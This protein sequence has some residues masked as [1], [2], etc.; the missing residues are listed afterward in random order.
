M[1]DLQILEGTGRELLPQLEQNPDF[2]F[3]LVP[4][5]AETSEDSEE[6]QATRSAKALK[7]YGILRGLSSTEEFLR[8]KQ[9]EIDWEDRNL[10]PIPTQTK[11][12]EASLTRPV[13]K[14]KGRGIL[15]GS[16]T[17]EEFLRRKHE[18][19]DREDATRKDK[20]R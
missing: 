19:A 17:L 16:T 11:S 15:K 3:L 4:L 18:D 12:D 13:K 1:A 7:S 10:T 14:L 5:P 9:E 2:R 20:D 8:R 6:E